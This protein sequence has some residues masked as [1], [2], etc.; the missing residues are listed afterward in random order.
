MAL[1]GRISR[2][3]LC[4]PLVPEISCSWEENRGL[5]QLS[6]AAVCFFGVKGPLG[7]T[8][9]E[10]L[11]RVRAGDES[12]FHELVNQHANDLYGLAYSLVG[13]SADA[14][15]VVQETLA[16]AF[17]GVGRFRG[18]ASIR[19][20]LT[21]ILVRQAARL[22]RWRSI[23]ITL[24]LHGRPA[25]SHENGLTTSGKQAAT[26]GKMDVTAMLQT[27]SQEHR[28]VIV[29]REIRGLSYE[30]IAKTLGIPRGT[31]ES[32]L[33]RARLELRERFSG[34][35]GTQSGS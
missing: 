5:A 8:D 23:R 1:L 15:D 14:E 21:Q 16:A 6:L 22:K 32:R 24:P 2:A 9:D 19:T 10:L 4:G 7:A 26:E 3:V 18:E 17:E 20:W 31:V 25:E 28:E 33:H 11:R 27:L 30:E 29:L 34:Y 13:N 35:W 12:A